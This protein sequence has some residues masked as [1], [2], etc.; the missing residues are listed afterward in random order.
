MHETRTHAVCGEGDLDAR[1]MLIAQAPGHN[2]D[3]EGRMFIGEAG[4]VLN[5][6]LET[7]GIRREEIYL[8]NILKCML[9][10]NRRPSQTE[11]RACNGYLVEEMALVNPEVIAPLGDYATRTVLKH[12]RL[13]RPQSK[14]EFINFSGKIFSKDD[15]KI[16]PLPHPAALLHNAAFKSGM[17]TQYKRLTKLRHGDMEDWHTVPTSW[18]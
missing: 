4:H 3:R 11:I 2:E 5:E 17:I 14:G 7:A 16:L 12:F 1:I 6:L 13:P 10:K 15:Y 18:E 8:T 9:P